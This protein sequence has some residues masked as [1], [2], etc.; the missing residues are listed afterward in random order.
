[1]PFTVSHS[2]AVLPLLRSRYFSATGL[3]IGSMAPDFE[4][5]FRMNVQGIYGHTIAGIFYF[6]VPVSLFLAFLFHSVVKQNLID[7]MPVFFQSRFHEVRHFDFRKYFS[8][9]K[10][11]FFL[12]VILGT[13]TH[14]VWD[15]FTHQHQFFVKALPQIYE[16]RTVPFRGGNYPLW[17]ALQQIST[18]VGGVAV[19]FYVLTMKRQEGTYGRMSWLYW[20]L[21]LI[22]IV[23]IVYLRMT[24][25]ESLNEKYVVV[26]ISIISAFCIGV[27]ILGLIPFRKSNGQKIS[28]GSDR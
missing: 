20:I 17:Y 7:S 25:F 8:D 23:A 27:T 19:V 21:L 3:I 13:V 2:A 1:M 10:M 16:G 4:Y 9:H 11:A 15:G 5:F 12:S 26:V 28:V 6:D 24:Y 22:M 14:I 18:A